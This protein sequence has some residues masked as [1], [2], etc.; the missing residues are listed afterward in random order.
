MIK[1]SPSFSDGRGV[2]EH[3]DGPRDLGQ[4]TSRDDGGRLVVDANLE[5]GG[6]PV[7]KLNKNGNLEHQPG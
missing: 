5:A 1:T 2:G 7:H 6:T 3:A 4:V